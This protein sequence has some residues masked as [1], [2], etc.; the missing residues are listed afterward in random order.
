MNVQTV[1]TDGVMGVRRRGQGGLLPPSWPALENF[2]P[3]LEKSLRTPMDGVVVVEQVALNLLWISCKNM[4]GLKKLFA[5]T[6]RCFLEPNLFY[7][8][9]FY[10]TPQKMVFVDYHLKRT[11]S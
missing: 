10:G 11:L 6:K 8:D 2:C 1:I 7:I 3:P 4:Q 9:C 5:A